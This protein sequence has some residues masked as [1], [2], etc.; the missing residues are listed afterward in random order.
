MYRFLFTYIFFL[1]CALPY[2]AQENLV[3]NGSFEEYYNCPG[4]GITECKYWYSPTLGSP[5]LFHVCA[6]SFNPQLGVPLN[7][8]GYQVPNTGDAYAGF[9]ARANDDGRE[10]LQIELTKPLEEGKK[11]TVQFYLNLGEVFAVSQW[12]IGMYLSNTAVSSP[13]IN[14]YVLNVPPQILNKEG[15]FL[16]WEEWTEVKGEYTAQGGEKFI[17]IG[18][19]YT[20]ANT[21]TLIIPGLMQFNPFKTYIYIDDVS[22]SEIICE[23]KLPNIFTPNDDGINDSWIT[24][25]CLEQDELLNITIYNRWGLK[26]HENTKDEIFWNGKTECGNNCPEGTYYYI[27]NSEQNSYKGT[28]QLLR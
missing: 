18:N 28:I 14:S 12:N 8:R 21:D 5:D 17:T 15:N 13:M 4:G 20:E 26:V 27:I 6:N 1:I 3:P 10:Y 25:L 23:P 16:I 9:Y 2:K 11:Y 7:S 19:F 24:K 22:I